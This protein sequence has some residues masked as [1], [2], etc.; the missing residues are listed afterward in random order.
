[1]LQE[2]TID[3]KKLYENIQAFQNGSCF[4]RIRNQPVRSSDGFLQ[5]LMTARLNGVSGMEMKT[6]STL[7]CARRTV[8][9]YVPRKD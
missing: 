5:T 3:K 8:D 6:S 9:N 1:M 7:D 2:F 4:S